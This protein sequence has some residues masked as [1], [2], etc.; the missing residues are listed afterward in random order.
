MDLIDN[1]VESYITGIFCSDI[2]NIDNTNK[3]I[4]L[5]FNNVSNDILDHCKEIFFKYFD[6]VKYIEEKKIL[7]LEIF[8]N[9]NTKFTN[10]NLKWHFIRGFFDICGTINFIENNYSIIIN[11]KIYLILNTIKDLSMIPCKLED[12]TNDTKT[13][14]FNEVNVLEFLCKIYKDSSIRLKKNYD[15]YVNIL[16]NNN[17]IPSFKFVKTCK[18]SI[19]PIKNNITDSGYDLHLIKKIKQVNN[20]YYY[21]TGIKIR[22]SIGYYFDLVG[23]SSIS[24]T[25]WMLA[26]NI[27]I[28]DMTYSG[29]IIVALIRVDPNAKELELPIKLV[30]LIPRKLIVMDFEEVKELDDTKRGEGGFGSSN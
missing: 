24:K 26:N 4:Y 3:C 23:R 11:S 25:G 27:G 12:N 28:I 16:T 6:N 1:E 18:D 15:I 22:P 17:K 30:Q 21:D 19:A 20:V 14:T 10:D 8:T 29:S 5:N 7:T 13:L 9:F 2:F